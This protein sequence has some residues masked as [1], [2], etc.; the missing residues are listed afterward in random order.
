M[1]LIRPLLRHNHSIISRGKHILNKISSPRINVC[2]FSTSIHWAKFPMGPPDPILGLN[3]AYAKDVNP[4]KVNLGVGAYRDD[5]GSPYVLKCV[6]DAEEIIKNNNENHEYAP[7]TGC[8]DFVKEAM[9]F[10]YGDDSK[11]LTENRV[12]ATQTLSGTGGLRVMG[13]LL[14]KFGHKHIYVPNPTWG[15]HIPIFANAGLEVRKYRYYDAAK[16][17]L[18]F[19]NL[20]ADLK[21]APE[22]SAVL[23]HVCAHNPTGMDPTMEQWSQISDVVKERKLL[24]FFDCAYQGFAS[25]N[26]P[27]D[28]AP[29][30]MFIEEGHELAL[31][32]S[33][34]KN[35]GLYGQRVGAL[36]IVCGNEDEAKKVLSQLK[37]VIR[38]MYSNPPRHG[39]RIVRT[40]LSDDELKAEF[41]DQCSDMASR[42][43]SMRVKLVDRLST[44]GSNRSWD[45]ITSQIGMFAYSGLTKDEVETLRERHSIYCTLDGRIS[46]AGVTS[47]NVGYIGDAIN[48]VTSGK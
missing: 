14:A 47:G 43:N 45:H 48:D 38:P 42:I 9:A 8:P 20:I 10:A 31:V 16:S 5:T 18:D 33:F 22:E 28:A 30:R 32:Q 27:Q 12:A 39:A 25:G 34:S 40:V 17:G 3:E 4:N 26:A 1:P 15:N 36:S 11:V 29:L 37:I 23:L 6:R 35:F 44:S 21:D 2:A 41:I 46:M 13:E 24:P 19:N 7:I